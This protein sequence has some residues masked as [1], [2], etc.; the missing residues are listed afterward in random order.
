MGSQTLDGSVALMCISM[1]H[2]GYVGKN[3]LGAGRIHAGELRG[4]MTAVCS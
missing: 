3:P 4:C 1:L 2:S